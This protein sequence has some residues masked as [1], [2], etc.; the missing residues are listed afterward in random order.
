MTGTLAL[1]VIINALGDY[2]MA[3][4]VLLVAVLA[5]GIGVLVF[6]WGWATLM[7][8]PEGSGYDPSKGSGLSRWQKSKY[9]GKGMIRF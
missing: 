7:N 5:I 1:A 9:A 4:L 2:G 6:R 3:I 8:M